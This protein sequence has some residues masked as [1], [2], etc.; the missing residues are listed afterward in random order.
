L[1]VMGM[2]IGPCD[3]CGEL[4]RKKVKPGRKRYHIECAIRAQAE[5]Q[6]G[7]HYGTHPDLQRSDEVG[8]NFAE[9]V[10]KRQGPSYEKWAR[11]MTRYLESLQ[12]QQSQPSDTLPD[13]RAEEPLDQ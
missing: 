8:D 13:D 3:R 1:N 2:Y 4:L 12:A 7:Y 10:R 5:Q 6:L 11:G 9:Q